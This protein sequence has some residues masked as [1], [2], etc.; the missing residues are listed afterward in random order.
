MKKAL[1]LDRDGIVN[2]DTTYLHESKDVVFMNG[3]FDVCKKAEELGYI[4]I[5]VTNQSGI[6]RGYYPIENVE[7][8]HVWMKGEFAR[9]GIFITDIFISPYHPKGTIPKYTATHNDRKPKPG[10]LLKAA[11]K[12]NIDFSKSLMV[13]DKSSDRIEIENLKSIILKSKYS[14]EDDAGYDIE[15]LREV[16]GFLESD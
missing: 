2:V 11:E 1:F 7:S 12:Y 3:I 8:L 10:M 15:D 13:G 4:I 16:I 5:I 14:V 9:R 6:A